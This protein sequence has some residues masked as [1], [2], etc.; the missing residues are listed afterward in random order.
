MFN[1]SSVAGQMKTFRLTSKAEVSLETIAP[2]E[3]IR[4]SMT[5]GVDKLQVEMQRIEEAL[6]LMGEIRGQ[7]EKAYFSL[8]SSESEL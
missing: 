2:Q 6:Q 1:I 4:F 3:E 7:I 8:F 5:E